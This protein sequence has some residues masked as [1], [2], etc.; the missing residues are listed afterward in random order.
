MV[1]AMGFAVNQAAYVALLRFSGLRYDV[2]L[3]LVLGAVAAM[4]FVAGRVWA[5]AGR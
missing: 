3:A 4:T 5:F 2:A 1:S